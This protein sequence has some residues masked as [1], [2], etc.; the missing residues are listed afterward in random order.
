MNSWWCV[1][2]RRNIVFIAHYALRHGKKD[3]KALLQGMQLQGSNDKATWANIYNTPDAS[4]FRSPHPYVM[5][6]WS[7]DGEVGAFG[8]LRILQTRMNSF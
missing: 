4:Q 3:D 2:L 5:G 8:Y 1:D 7:V 6:R